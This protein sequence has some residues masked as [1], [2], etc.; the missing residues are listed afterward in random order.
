MEKHTWNY[1]L[2][3]ER[4]FL[5]S[6]EFVEPNN[7]NF[8]SFSNWYAKL[9]LLV[10]SEVDVVAKQICAGCPNGQ[11]ASNI[12]DYRKVMTTTFPGMH[13]VE[14]EVPRY[15]LAL[16]PWISWGANPP[17]IPQWWKDYNSVKHERNANFPK[18]NLENVLNCF[19][20]LLIL[21]LYYYRSEG[22]LQPYPE[23]FD[24]G[25]PHYMVTE[26]SPRLPGLS[27]QQ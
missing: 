19:A 11:S 24:A 10:G 1:F 23:L 14:I 26:D 21:E 2:A 17:T 16:K 12:C 9:L 6:T 5:R 22:H 18:A 8:P 4:D 7:S 20:G 25:F 27:N 13:D 15:S 3:L